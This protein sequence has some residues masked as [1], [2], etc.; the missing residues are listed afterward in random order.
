V[1]TWRSLI[2]CARRALARDLAPLPSEISTLGGHFPAG[3][4]FSAEEDVEYV[5]EDAVE[6]VGDAGDPY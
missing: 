2:H 1:V 6:D 4:R 5:A 3:G